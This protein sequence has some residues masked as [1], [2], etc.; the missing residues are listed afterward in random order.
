MCW[1]GTVA[2]AIPIPHSWFRIC[3]RSGGRTESTGSTRSKGNSETLKEGGWAT[4]ERL[5][6]AA[7]V[8]VVAARSEL[9]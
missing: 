9:F 8:R 2:G 5:P 1:A 7:P 6:G 4:A 3:R